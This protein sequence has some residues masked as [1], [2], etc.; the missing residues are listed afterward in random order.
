MEINQIRRRLTIMSDEIAHEDVNYVIVDWNC[1]AKSGHF[2][3][4]K[5]ESRMMKY[6]SA[7]IPINGQHFVRSDPFGDWTAPFGSK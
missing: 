5:E 6:F 7:A 1:F 3:R 4:M 2:E